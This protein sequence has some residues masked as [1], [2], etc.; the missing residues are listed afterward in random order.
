MDNS[1]Q[2]IE[3]PRR[4]GEI[5]RNAI[6]TRTWKKN[7][8]ILKTLVGKDF[9]VKYR[10]SVLGVVWS[11]LNPLLMMIVMSAV[12]S[13]MFRFNIENFPLYLILG[14][15]MF[16]L[17]S[18]ATSGAMQSIIGAASLI[19][20]IRLEKVIF[21]LVNFLFSA[22]AAVAVMIYFQVIPTWDIL[23]L[24]LLIVYV[25]AFSAGLG[26]ILAS[27]AVFFRDVIHLW[28]VVLTAWTYATP[29]F[30]PV[31]L[32]PEILQQAIQFNPM[33]Q[34]ILYFRNIMMYNITPTIEQNLICIA[35]AA[36]S[37]ALGIWVFRKTEHKFILYV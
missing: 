22:I 16:S 10:R 37:L 13:Y 30:Y 12:F 28:S 11:V 18:D 14:Q 19:Q 2:A 3:S 20:K 1:S 35:M 33:Y 31:E 5:A 15:I 29:L 23:F 25:V 27:L 7:W 21:S 32:L 36:I 8:F 9:K 26:L 4:D 17:M 34:Y 24:P 6:E